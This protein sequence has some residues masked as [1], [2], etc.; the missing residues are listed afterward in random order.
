MT[1][2]R[3][4][5]MALRQLLCAGCWLAGS[6]WAAGDLSMLSDFGRPDPGMER[7]GIDR[8]TGNEGA[9]EQ[10]GS[11]HAASIDQ[12]QG[13]GNVAVVWQSGVAG[14][15]TF[16]QK[17]EGNEARVQQL[18]D[19][20]RVE[21]IQQGT[22]NQLAA[23]QAGSEALLQGQQIG[24]LNQVAADMQTGAQLTFLQQGTGNQI[25]AD[26][27]TGM[28]PVDVQQIG[29]HLSVRIEPSP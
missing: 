23:H 29:D 13:R 17:G 24:S 20:H 15:A 5:R 25:S 1:R 18:G 21:L 6:A 2:N 16:Q 26:L 22:G 7:F 3:H 14:L 19:R 11:D 28:A 8:V 12:Q 27:R 4:A 9:I 10:N